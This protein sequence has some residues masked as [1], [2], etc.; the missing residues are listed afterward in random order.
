MA[1]FTDLVRAQRQSGK[2]VVTSLSGAY[3][4]MNMQKYDPR[5]ALFSRGGLMTALFPELKGYQATA[6]SRS[7]ASLMAQQAGSSPTAMSSIARDAR[8]SARNSMALPSIARNMAQLVRISGGTPAKYFE[9]AGQRE[10][11]YESKYGTGR[12]GM[13]GLGK[14]SAGGGFNLLGMLGGVGSLVGSAGSVIGSILGGIGSLVGG[15]FR[16]IFGVLGGALGNMGFMGVVLAGVVGFALYSLYKSLDFSKLGSGI[17]ESLS[18]IKE[19]LSGLYKELDGL[20]GG[21][22][23][24]FIEDTQKMFKKTT[25]RIAAG[26]ETALNLFRDLGVAVI[27]DMYGFVY[28]IF[29]ENQGKVLGMVTIGALAAFAGV[30]SLKGAAVAAAISAAMAAYGAMTGEKSLEDMKMDLEETKNARAKVAEQLKAQNMPAAFYESRN[31]ALQQYD[32][33]IKR[34]ETEITEK[35]ARTSNTQAVLNRMTVEGIS[36]Q[37]QQNL[38]NREAGSPTP[39]GIGGNISDYIASKEGFATKAYLD[40][41][42]NTKN[43]YSI[44]YGHLITP[45]EIKQGYINLGDKKVEVRGSGGK[46]TTISKEDAKALLQNDIPKYEKVA[47]DSLGVDAWSKLNTEQRNA[48]TSL[49]YNSGQAGINHLIKKGL[50]DAIMKGDVASASQIISQ[51]GFTMAGGKV[52]SVLQ[53]RR[54]EEAA[55]FA[56]TGTPAQQSDRQLASNQSPSPAS[57]SVAPPVMTTEKTTSMSDSVAS[58]AYEQITALDRMMGGKL[59][60]GSTALADMLRDITREFMSNPTFVDNSQTVNN[61]T[62][63]AMASSSIGSAYNADATNL[64]VDRATSSYYG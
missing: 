11:A 10:A 37:Y 4:Q 49:V 14:S 2:S 36:T 48:L 52:Y 6:S 33:K 5:N 47:A 18:G 45:H 9:R 25:D 35:E 31:K 60:Q 54:K 1:S 46:D 8:I 64:L 21:R 56:G 28:N 55:M 13:S 41:P 19:S 17:G 23:S 38:A 30:G 34:Q 43:Q 62:P 63:S 16:G 53:Q 59:M 22:L 61:S 29:K 40:P 15:A 32:E 58:L 57:A 3:N 42:G 39:V 26:M 24:T 51:H 44:G 7:S 50:R 27:K 20:T 12:K